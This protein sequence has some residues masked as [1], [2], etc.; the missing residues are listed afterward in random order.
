MSAGKQLY[1]DLV[2]VT[3]DYLGPAAK[4]FIDRQIQNHL[5]KD[6]GNLTV[7]ELVSLIDWSVLALSLLTKDE[8]IKVEYSSRLKMLGVGKAGV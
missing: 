7:K 2:L 6:P 5:Q 4:R 3:E 1:T 8:K